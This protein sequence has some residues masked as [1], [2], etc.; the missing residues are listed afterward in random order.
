MKLANVDLAN[1]PMDANP[2][3]RKFM[4]FNDCEPHQ[5]GT[6]APRFKIP[7]RAYLIG[8]AKT[9]D[10]SSKKWARKA[11]YTH[12]HESSVGVYTVAK[13]KVPHEVVSTPDQ[14]RRV[15]TLWRLGWCIGLAYLA[16]DGEAAEAVVRQPYPE[17]YSTPSGHCLLVVENKARLIALIWGGKLRITE[18]GIEG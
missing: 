17:L 5:V 9:T 11:N 1:A 10:Y 14:V 6:F 4:E 16:L 2:S 3:V 8:R 13:P 7:A 15:G 12:D 18:H